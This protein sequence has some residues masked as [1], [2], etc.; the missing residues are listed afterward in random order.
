MPCMSYDDRPDYSEREWKAKTDRL[1]R[2]ACAAMTELE[3]NGAEDL[4]LLKNEEV[5]EWWVAHKEADR[6]AQERAEA[7]RKREEIRQ[8]ALAKLTADELR[9]LGIKQKATKR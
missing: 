4:L 7:E 3:K 9:V 6:K 8:S 1:A 2:I 5:R